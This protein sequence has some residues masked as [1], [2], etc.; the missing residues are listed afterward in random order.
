MNRQILIYSIVYRY[1]MTRTALCDFCLLED[2]ITIAKFT[3]GTA[4]KGNRIAVCTGHKK[5][6]RKI[7]GDST[8]VMTLLSDASTKSFALAV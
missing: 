6:V 3:S 4:M 5:D 7:S 2:K 1:S 8:K